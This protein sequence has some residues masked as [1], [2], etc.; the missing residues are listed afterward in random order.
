MQRYSLAAAVLP[1]LVAPLAAAEP[2]P[3]AK[4]VREAVERVLPLIHKGGA[5]HM[6][7]RTCFACHNQAIP[8]FALTAARS[9]GFAIKDEEIAKHMRF[10]ADF[11]DRNREN[12][13]Q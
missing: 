9:R 11:L 8:V 10:I 12:Y 2:A 4:E 1:V 6:A 13:L 5:G 7:E 3:T